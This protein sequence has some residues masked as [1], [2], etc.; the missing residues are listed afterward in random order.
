MATWLR[1]RLL[2]AVLPL[3]GGAALV[4]CTDDVGYPPAEYIAVRR[5]WAPGERAALIQRITTNH[6]YVFPY[7][8]DISDLAPQLYADVDSVTVLIR[9]PAVSPSLTGPPMSAA[10]MG[11]AQAMFSATWNFIAL[12]ITTINNNATPKDTLFW[13]LALWADPANAGDHGFAIAFS[14]TNT[15]NYSPIDQIAFDAGSGKVGSAAGEFHLSTATLWTD[16]GGQGNCQGQ[17]GAGRYQV[18]SQT[19]PGAFSTITTG[20]YLGGQSRTGTA[21]GQVLDSRVTRLAGAENPTDFTVSFDYRVAGLPSTE[22]LCVFPSPC[23]T[24]VPLIAPYREAPQ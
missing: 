12:K 18:T 15:F 17:C 6:E 1:V 7:V 8:G 10:M 21:F 4:A 24:N 13:H 11:P 3:G 9:N 20:P 14:R 22:I 16:Q 19:Y 23:T 2:A 5:A